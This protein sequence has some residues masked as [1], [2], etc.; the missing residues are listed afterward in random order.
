[1]RIQL[2]LSL[3][4]MD[5][6]IRSQHEQTRDLKKSDES[7][8]KKG[9][10]KSVGPVVRPLWRAASSGAKAKA[11]PLAARLDIIRVCATLYRDIMRHT[12]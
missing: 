12:L 4:A 1:M 10:L 2:R 6:E 3:S 7:K 5:I 11:P 9:S 8:G